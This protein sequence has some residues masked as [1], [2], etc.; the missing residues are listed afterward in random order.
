MQTIVISFLQT[1]FPLLLLFFGPFVLDYFGLKVMTS[2][3][4]RPR[5]SLTRY[6]LNK[7][8]TD[9]DVTVLA[10]D[11]WYSINRAALKDPNIS[12]LFVKMTADDETLG[13]IKNSIDKSDWVFTQIYHNLAKVFLSL[14]YTQTDINGILR[15][16]SMFV[17]SREQYR[18]LTEETTGDSMIDLGAGDGATTMSMAPSF[19]KVYATETSS[20]MRSLLNDKNIEVLPVD[21]WMKYGPFDMISCL[22]LLDR[23]E[24]PHSLLQHVKMALKPKGLFLVA[25]VLPYKPYVESNPTHKPSEELDISGDVLEDQIELAIKIVELA[26]FRLLK[27]TRVPYL[28]EGDLNQ[29]IYHLTDFVMIFKH[30]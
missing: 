9:Q 6:L 7:M 23:A 25:L 4:Y 13:F 28:C 27:W 15:R 17:L 29:P 22:N 10:D 2:Q 26:G 30:K 14:F 8:H 16:G 3:N 11:K 1:F 5:S 24:R 19:N 12:E 18:S 20:P 21:T